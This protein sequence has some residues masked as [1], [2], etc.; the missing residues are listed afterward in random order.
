MTL[1]PLQHKLF[2]EH[3]QVLLDYPV[4]L[5]LLGKTLG[6]HRDTLR[7][8]RNYVQRHGGPSPVDFPG[9]WH[10][11]IGDAHSGPGQDNWRW[12]ALGQEI[13][14]LGREAMSLGITLHVIQNGDLFD[15]HSLSSYDVGKAA[16]WNST[17]AKDLAAV[18]T[19]LEV[20]K[21]NVSKEVWDY[22]TWHWTKGNHEY[23]EDRYMQDNPSLQG[24]LNGPR[25]ILEE[26][27]FNC[28]DFLEVLSLDGV[29]YV[30]YLQNT[31]NAS[32]VGG[33]NHA[34]SLVLKGY[35]SITVGHSHKL[36]LYDTKDVHGR[37]IRTLVSGCFFDH[38]ES[39]A[40][41]SNETW[42][43]GFHIC[44]NVKNGNYDLES[45]SLESLRRKY[46]EA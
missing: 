8:V 27:G 4:N 40:G 13:E 36:D 17:Y 2:L 25:Q 21:A 24:T 1:T 12:R 37:P 16:A 14:A 11:V 34:R 15:L 32:A 6:V 10:V 45:R 46:P 31:G 29:A 7:T 33:V 20:L 19:A 30:H 22:C 44:R 41:R 26:L 43:R 28:Y 35:A 38:H 18:K 9:A 23:R 39:Y 3:G 5:T 42:W